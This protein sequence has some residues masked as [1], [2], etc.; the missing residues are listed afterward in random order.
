M[1]SDVNKLISAVYLISWIFLGNFMLLNLFLAILLDSFAEDDVLEAAKKKSAE[2]LRQDA[3]EARNEFMSK[4]GEELILEYAESM[5]N[6]KGNKNKTG[7]F[8]KQTKKK[9]KNDDK[10]MDESFEL[11]DIAMK[12]KKAVVKEKKPDYWGVE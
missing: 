11:E 4:K 8:V 7:G 5:G 10:F 1:R 12:Q 6:M 2:E 9:I 3:I